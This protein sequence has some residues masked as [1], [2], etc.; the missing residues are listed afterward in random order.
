[1]LMNGDDS[2]GDGDCD[3]GGGDSDGEGEGDGGSGGSMRPRVS[4]R[5]SNKRNSLKFFICIT[6]TRTFC[7]TI[8]G[9]LEH[10]ARMCLDFEGIPRLPA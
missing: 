9:L 6:H 4:N 2:G 7:G 8:N 10:S 1:M 5:E 3:V